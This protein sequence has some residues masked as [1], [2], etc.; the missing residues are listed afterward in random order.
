MTGYVPL[1]TTGFS[2]SGGFSIHESDALT[3]YGCLITAMLCGKFAD[4]SF[5][6]TSDVEDGLLVED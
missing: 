5:S 6:M 1:A 3:Y 4:D 2:R